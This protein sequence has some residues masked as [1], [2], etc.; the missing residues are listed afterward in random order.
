VLLASLAGA[1]FGFF[2]LPKGKAGTSAKNVPMA[3]A[4]LILEAAAD[5]IKDA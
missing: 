4:A 3:V 5:R 1:V 2:G